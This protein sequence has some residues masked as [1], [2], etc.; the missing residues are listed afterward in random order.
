MA[1]RSF[2]EA[3]YDA[4]SDVYDD[5]HHPA[6]AQ[7][8][9]K[10]ADLRP[11]E[12]VLDLACGTGLATFAAAD[13]VGP[14]GS[15]TGID[16]STGMLDQARK[17]KAAGNY[18][19]VFLYAHDIADLDSLPAVK[20]KQFDVIIEASA[21]VLMDDALACA[22]SYLS[23]LRP[24]GRYVVDS[25][26]SHT[27]PDG[28]AMELTGK[29]LDVPVGYNTSWAV[30]TDALRNL[31]QE[32]GFEVHSVV[33]QDQD[34]PAKELNV[35]D[36]DD[37]FDAQVKR[38]ALDN[39]GRDEVREKAREKF[40]EIFAGLATRDGVVKIDPRVCVA[41]AYKPK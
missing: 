26:T 31:L 28:L 17:K 12:H 29:A 40:R 32:A 13:K 7:W 11:G 33:L 10:H 14:S 9:V 4:R 19:N 37:I 15:V 22:K 25:H 18:D 16:V 21:L 8:M 38:E 1:Q 41:I 3:S 35:S 6:F 2:A 39:L 27:M 20:G 5:S 36:A 24:G 34:Y 23:Y 30:S